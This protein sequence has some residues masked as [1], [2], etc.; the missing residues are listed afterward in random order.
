MKN[1]ELAEKFILYFKIRER[2]IKVSRKDENDLL[3]EM[4]KISK[5]IL[6]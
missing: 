3:D 2:V 5:D 4:Y 1:K 6:K